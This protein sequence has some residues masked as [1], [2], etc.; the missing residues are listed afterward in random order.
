[1][2]TQQQIKEIFE[3][4]LDCS[5][6]ER[7]QLLAELCAN[8]AV[9]RTEVESLLSAHAESDGFLAGSP[10]GNLL[11]DRIS[12]I[13]LAGRRI[14]VYEL[15]SE[16]GQGGMATVYL[17]ERMDGEFRQQV[18]L[19][20][21]WPGANAEEITRR[22][23]QERQILASLDHHNIARL[24][25]GGTTEEGLPYLVMEYITG[26]PITH[27][28]RSH[29][30]SLSERLRLFQTVCSAV[31][32]AHR[33]L[34]IHRDIKPGNILVTE[35]GTV[36][37]LDFGIAKLLA[38]DSAGDV[39]P[40]I[41]DLRPMTP[42]YASPEQLREETIT[43][44][45]DV[46]SLGVLLYELLTGAHPFELK[47]LPLHELTRVVCEEDPPPPS[48]KPAQ[49]KQADQ[50][51]A[52]DNTHH[53]SFIIHHSDLRGDLDNI[54]LMALRKDAR[55]RYQTVE[56]FSEDIS[57]YLAGNIV[58]A[59]PATLLYRASKFIK[60]HKTQ[61]A[62]ALVSLVAMFAFLAREIQQRRWVEQQNLSQR[63][64]LYATQMQQA[65]RD[66]EEANIAPVRET[67]TAWQPRSGE[68][69][70]RG[71][72]WRYLWKLVNSDLRTVFSAN[73]IHAIALSPNG[74]LIA[75]GTQSNTVELLDVKNGQRPELLG[76]HS[77]IVRAVAFSPDG[78]LLASSDAVGVVKIWNVEARREIRQIAGH[79]NSIVHSIAFSPD[80]QTLATGGRDKTARL[81]EIATGKE[82]FTLI[83]HVAGFRV[84]V[85]S[86]DGRTLFTGS[87]DPVIR[88]WDVMTGHQYIELK[89]LQ[90]EAYSMA[91]TPDGRYLAACG[92]GKEIKMWELATEK[93]VRVFAG[94]TDSVV[95]ILFSP[96]RK[97]LA[98]S[99]IDRT[100][101]LWETAT[102]R[103]LV[104][105][106][107]HNYETSFLAFT[108]D[109]LGLI[110][111][112]HKELKF[113]EVRALLRPDILPVP[114][115]CQIET[116]SLSHDGKW[117]A[118]GESHYGSL[119]KPPASIVVWEVES[120]K[121]KLMI[122]F[123]PSITG[124]SFLPSGNLLAYTTR[125]GLAD[126]LDTENGQK[127]AQF[128]GHQ[129]VSPALANQEIHSLDASPDG[130]LIA[131]GD[132]TNSVKL[133][134]P[135]GREIRTLIGPGEFSESAERAVNA[136]AFSPDGRKLALGGFDSGIDVFDTASGQKLLRMP[137]HRGVLLAI[138]F[139]PDGRM[140]ASGGADSLVKIW[141]ATNGQLLKTLKG[142]GNKVSTL[143]WTPDSNRLA[144]AGRDNAI[145]IWN[146]EL[147]QEVLSLKGHSDPITSLAFSSDGN[148]LVSA[149]WD[150]TVRFWKAATEEEIRKHAH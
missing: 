23:K 128:I 138:K 114:S 60:R 10:L 126:I 31:A 51:S 146:V 37:L 148:L 46:Y 38:P 150:G 25:D 76:W 49:A 132:G 87:D 115:R 121:K 41:T 8:D 54:V 85:F 44:A 22:F 28:C 94:H 120:L 34:V 116:I 134:A 135:D 19:K 93:I 50:V 40:T 32:Y 33:N 53:S 106:K 14:G 70:L 5:P 108:S 18:A 79:G 118:T 24:L 71:F 143:A 42:E 55:L 67:L 130:Q 30:L 117:L 48:T 36:K 107:G 111:G 77:G 113:W 122:Q 45:T 15:Q 103:E 133:W 98:S 104:V 16:I 3:A 20:I 89:G 149:G 58:S 99:S 65:L 43:T 86:P 1:M 112:D 21:V 92:P 47:N 64:L 88:G 84:V 95:S 7:E 129:I 101:R 147:G 127:K 66:C 9:V 73:A 140:I 78:K 136:V 2:T 137:G 80:G 27:Y 97:M 62:V 4:A 52:K 83:G 119:C 61:L 123:Q 35:D 131:S 69:D 68:E 75:L 6:N 91:V 81:W 145:K 142:Q 100:V 124:L 56:Q 90:S 125:N 139:S 110:T 17:A 82:L 39:Q 13:D 26:Q 72:E 74:E 57:R 109:G 11:F 144:S 29:E 141:D 96:D 63:R 59:R 102:G 105:V 12:A